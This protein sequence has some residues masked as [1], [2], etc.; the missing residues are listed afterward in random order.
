MDRVI[1]RI[2]DRE[3][4]QW[5]TVQINRSI[6]NLCG[7]FTLGLTVPPQAEWSS[8]KQKRFEGR[9]K[10]EVLIG[11]I[12][13]IT[14]S[15]DSVRDSYTSTEHMVEVS[16][17]DAAADL[18]DC[19]TACPTYKSTTFLEIAKTICK[20]FDIT[21]IDR[22]G[23]WTPKEYKPQY[24]S[25]AFE[26]LRSFIQG[27]GVHLIS[28][29]RGRLTIIQLGGLMNRGFVMPMPLN[30]PG[31]VISAE[32]S[33]DWRN[34]F[35]DYQVVGNYRSRRHRIDSGRSQGLC[36][37]AARSRRSSRG[38]IGSRFAWECT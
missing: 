37:A 28:D 34:I 8:L 29:G 12:P 7:D 19:T 6:E 18:F 9:E 36:P 10:C 30:F 33:M 22:A 16:G 38:V 24:G 26:N 11:K 32:R 27:E 4:S 14:G 15:L 3:Y 35:Q 25:T 23:G 31:N 1:L 13:V 20:A 21:V 17:R 5:T 2:N